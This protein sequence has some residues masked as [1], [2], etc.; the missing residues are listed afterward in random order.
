[1]AAMVRRTYRRRQAGAIGLGDA[2]GNGKTADK[3]IAIP[4]PGFVN[5]MD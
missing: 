1:M 4:Y 2:R 3:G 5:L